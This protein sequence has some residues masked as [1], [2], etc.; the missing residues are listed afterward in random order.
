VIVDCFMFCSELDLLEVRLHELYEVVDYFVLVEATR[1]HSG[2]PKPL[3]YR[4]NRRRFAKFREKIIPL[5]VDDMPITPDEVKAASKL[6]DGNWANGD[7]VGPNWTRERYQRDAMQRILS[8]FGDNDII[9]LGDADEIVRA[10]V[11]EVLELN[12][13]P[14]LTAV[15]QSLHS[16]Y[17]N[18]VCTNMPW[19]GTKIF[20]KK[21]M[22]TLSQ[23]RF[24]TP[25]VATITNGGWHFSF[26]GG[27]DAI[28]Q[29][30]KAYVHQEFAV[31]SVLDH[32]QERLDA[33]DDALGRLY[34]YK[35]VPI[36]IRFPEYI[37]THLGQFQ[38]W[39]Y[40]CIPQVT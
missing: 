15:E 1:T 4:Q 27:E 7:I 13:R 17:L 3:Y 39:I 18:W 10:G 33:G 22:T 21:Y 8:Q 36:D 32:I 5:V 31:P 34:E 9:I 12:L 14:G 19:K 23:D 2:K 11:V 28:K 35:I 16:Y 40:R 29:K 6:T 24:H 37:R 26:M 25:P 38:R 20:R 30:I